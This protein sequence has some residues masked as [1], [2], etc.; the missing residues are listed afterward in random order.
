MTWRLEVSEL[1][2][3]KTS[4]YSSM[5]TPAVS[6]T[7]S[8]MIGWSAMFAWAAGMPTSDIAL[9]AATAQVAVSFVRVRI[10]VLPLRV[11]RQRTPYALKVL[12]GYEHVKN[13]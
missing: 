1:S 3:T 2:G 10:D 8:L 7:N 11:W 6:V 4:M 13:R 5:S 12:P 9:T